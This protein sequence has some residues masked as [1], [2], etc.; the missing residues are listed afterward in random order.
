[1]IHIELDDEGTATD[2][3]TYGAEAVTGGVDF[4]SLGRNQVHTGDTDE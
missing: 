2:V 3:N 4:V 1:M